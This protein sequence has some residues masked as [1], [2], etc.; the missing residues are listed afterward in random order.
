MGKSADRQR[1]GNAKMNTAVESLLL[2]F[3]EDSSGELIL[4]VGRRLGAEVIPVKLIHGEEEV[5][6]LYK[7]LTDADLN[8]DKE[9]KHDLNREHRSL[10]V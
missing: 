6:G 4:L 9:K 7:T 2:G 5:K 10:G 8:L 3:S 1:R